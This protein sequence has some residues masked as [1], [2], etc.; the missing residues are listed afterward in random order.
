MAAR[1]EGGDDH[2][3]LGP[4]PDEPACKAVERLSRARPAPRRSSATGC[5]SAG[6]SIADSCLETVS[7]AGRSAE[8]AVEKAVQCDPGHFI[9]LPGEVEGVVG[10]GQP[11]EQVVGACLVEGHGERV[12]LTD[13]N[14]LIAGA[15][16]QEG[17]GCAIDV[18]DGERRHGPRGRTQQPA[19]EKGVHLRTGLAHRPSGADIAFGGIDVGDG[20]E[21]SDGCHSVTAVAR[22]AVS[23]AR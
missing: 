23:N 22:Y 1:G 13:G 10:S 17:G 21:G 19:T 3:K 16:G 9:D 20:I 2:L 4:A 7:L 12:R 11:Y 6:T 5:A 18:G 8:V 14:E 15:V